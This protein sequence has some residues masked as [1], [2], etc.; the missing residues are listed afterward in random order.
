M[1]QGKG[2]IFSDGEI[3]RETRTFAARFFS[4][5]GL[6][7]L[8]KKKLQSGMKEKLG[9]CIQGYIDGMKCRDGE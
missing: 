6:K 8:T 4:T 9:K 7:S 3:H 2:L 5:H 1:F